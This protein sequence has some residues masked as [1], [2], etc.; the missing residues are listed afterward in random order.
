MVIPGQVR[1]MD[2]LDL[3]ELIGIS[4]EDFRRNLERARRHSR[5][6]PSIFEKQLSRET[7]GKL[8]ERLWRFHGFYVVPRT[9]RKYPRPIAAHVL[10]YIGEVDERMI[11]NDPY[12]RP[13]DYIGMSGLERFYEEYLRGTKGV[14]VLLVDVHTRVQGSF[15][16]GLH[17]IPSIPG[18]S[19][20]STLDAEVQEFAERL[21]QNKR[22]S[23]VAIE[24]ATGEILVLVSSPTYDPNLLVGRVRSANFRRLQVD[25]QRPLFNRAIQAE[26][27]PGSIFKIPQGL[28]AMQRGVATE[29]SSFA[30]DQTHVGCRPHQTVRNMR[31]AVKVS[32]N[33]YFVTAFR[34]L[35][36]PGIERNHFLDSRIGLEQWNKDIRSFGMGER[37]GIDLPGGRRGLIPTVEFYDRI[38]GVNRWAFS[39]IRSVSIGQGEVGITPLQMANLAAISANRGFFITPHLARTFNDSIIPDQDFIERRY[40]TVDPKHFESVN[41]GMFDAV[42]E[43]GG[44]ARRARI[45]GIAVAGKTGTVQNPHGKNHAT[46]IAFAPFDNPKIAIAVFVENS[47]FGGT[48]AAPIASLVIEKYLTREIKRTEL[49]QQVKDA[50]F[51]STAAH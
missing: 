50:N 21:M 29:H 8:Q 3:C 22:G 36:Q 6:A 51:M 18:M 14:Q 12:Y 5:F 19:L 7:Y 9:V 30:C 13:G 41:W 35:I 34:R 32:C 46:F 44:T 47:G 45:D 37:L 11:E 16:D 24:P 33:P 43:A 26:Y 17:D 42:H 1:E 27:P 39:N 20:Q 49:M 15:R 23:V 48:W 2:T 28:I 31:E 40:T 38:Y 25:P 10:G 4:I